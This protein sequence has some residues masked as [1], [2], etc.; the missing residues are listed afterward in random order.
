MGDPNAY[1]VCPMCRTTAY[2]N[3]Q[4][5]AGCGHQFS[6]QFSP[7][8]QQTQ[9]FYGQANPHWDPYQSQYQLARPDSN[10]LLV[11][12]LLWF[13]LGHF[14]AHRFYL[15]HTNTA[16]L[17]LVLNLIG[18]LTACF[19]VGYIFLLGVA[20]WWIV[21]LVQMLTGNLRPTDGARLV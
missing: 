12:I 13:F 8:P 11:T 1:K 19:L 14:G 7:P 21:D 18:W 5:C 6:T 16:V 17:M 20:V 10:R 15:G 4:V 9:A 2:L 3:A